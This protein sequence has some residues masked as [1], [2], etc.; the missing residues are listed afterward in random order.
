MKT[1]LA[2]F[3]LLASG[4][5]AAQTGAA[6]GDNSKSMCSIVIKIDLS[7]YGGTK[8]KSTDSVTVCDDGKTK[9]YHS[10]SAPGI[11]SGQPERTRW[12]YNHTLDQGA[13]SDLKKIAMRTDIVR[14]PDRVDAIQTPSPLDLLM[15]V[16]IL[17]QGV[18]RTITLLFPSLSC[19]KDQPEMPEAAWDLIC[20]FT[21]VYSRARTGNPPPGTDCGCKSLH[22]MAV[23]RPS[24]QR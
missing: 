18:E 8:D 11:G 20:L 12:D 1:V 3:A 2:I 21:D 22:A 19:D 23:V 9:A 17:D 7:E 6:S 15:Q 16:T 5:C 13:L 14:L 24:T 4:L 10:F